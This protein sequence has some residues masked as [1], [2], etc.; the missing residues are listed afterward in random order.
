MVRIL[1]L[2]L[3]FSALIF[4]QQLST[5]VSSENINIT[6]SVIYTIKIK[7][8]EENP[9]I[10]ISSLEN[11]FS[12]IAGPNIGSEYK[13]INGEKS[14]SRSISWTLIPLSYGVLNIPS[15]EVDISGKK[16]KTKPFK[17]NVTKQALDQAIKE[18]FLEVKV[19]DDNVV[20]GEQVILTYTFYTRIASKVLSTEFP[21]YSD[22]WVEKLFDPVGIQF[23]PESWNDIEIE[24]YNLNI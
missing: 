5:S 12:I 3:F 10:D 13:F 2:N 9:I 18:L 23:T 4:P 17:I 22:F 1:I 14:S 7:D 11:F 8:T 6:E 16:I 21:E 20:V 24:G 15:F 19:S